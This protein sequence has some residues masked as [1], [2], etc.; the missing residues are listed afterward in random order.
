MALNSLSEREIQ[1]ANV[2]LTF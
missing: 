2:Q 1:K